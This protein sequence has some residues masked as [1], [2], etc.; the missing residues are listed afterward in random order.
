MKLYIFTF[1]H[2]STIQKG[3]QAAHVVAELMYDATDTV[4]EWFFK[5]KTIVMLEGG[6]NASM[7]YLRDLA[8]DVNQELDTAIFVEDFETL[9]GLTTAVAVLVPFDGSIEVQKWVAFSE[10]T[11]ELIRATNNK[12]KVII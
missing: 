12:K 7:K 3:I 5:H 1:N 6:N 9:G 8:L 10:P 2:L 11:Q 4:E